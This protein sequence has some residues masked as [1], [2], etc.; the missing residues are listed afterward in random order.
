MVGLINKAIIAD[1]FAIWVGDGFGSP[2]NLTLLTS[3]LVSFC[4]TFQLYFDFCGYCDMAV[5][6]ALFFLHQVTS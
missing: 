2:D 6:S 3:W 5:G 4:Y 1:K